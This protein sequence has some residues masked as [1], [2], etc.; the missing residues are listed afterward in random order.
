MRS[1]NVSDSFVTVIGDQMALRRPVFAPS[2]LTLQA[3]TVVLREVNSVFNIHSR[4][5][6]ASHTGTYSCWTLQS[7]ER[8]R[9]VG[10][11]E[12]GWTYL[13][14]AA[15]IGH[16]VSMVCRCFQQW[17]VEHSYTRRSGTGR[18]RSTDARQDRS[19]M[20][21]AVAARTASREEIRAHVATAVSQRTST[22]WFSTTLCWLE[23]NIY[24]LFDQNFCGIDLE[25]RELQSPGRNQDAMKKRVETSGVVSDVT[26]S[27]RGRG[28]LIFLPYV[29]SNLSL[30]TSN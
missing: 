9:I 27:K 17:S 10:L 4:Y 16:N 29:I 1:C 15:H 21:A 13:Q 12:A 11:R 24:V 2:V 5:N 18:P 20:R 28:E 7:F 25:H 14:I 8:G 6:H 30:R 22:F 19:I 26:I 3:V 23:V